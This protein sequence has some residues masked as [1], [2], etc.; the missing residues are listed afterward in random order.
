MYEGCGYYDA[1]AEVF[2]NE[3]CP[4]WYLDSLILLSVD[5]EYGACA[6]C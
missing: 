3:E 6:L 1:G 2:C 4:L 5:G